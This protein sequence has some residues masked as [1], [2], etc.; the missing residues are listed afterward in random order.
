MLKKMLKTSEPR[1][2]GN[3]VVTPKLSSGSQEVYFNFSNRGGSARYSL[4]EGKFLPV[5]GQVGNRMLSWIED[6]YIQ[7]MQ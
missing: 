4:V 7:D 3:F 1:K 2:V 5:R 6:T